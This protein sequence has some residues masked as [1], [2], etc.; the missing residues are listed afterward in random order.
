MTG[1]GPGFSSGAG[2]TWLENRLILSGYNYKQLTDLA[3]EIK[4][5]LEAYPRL[6]NVRTDLTRRYLPADVFETTLY[7]N[8]SALGNYRLSAQEV[9]QQLQPILSPFSY[10]RRLTISG[11][12]KP[13][14]VTSHQH[15]S[16][17]P[18]QLDV[19]PLSTSSGSDVRL[20]SLANLNQKPAPPLIERENRQYY[21]VIAFDYLA[22]YRFAEQFVDDFLEKTKVPVGFQ[23][24]KM[25]GFWLEVGDKLKIAPILILSFL[26][27]YMV[28]AGLYESFSYPLFIFLVIPFSLIGVFLIYYLTGA[29]F[30]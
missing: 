14:T 22:P 9:F 4:T 6:R 15:K 23:L 3:E 18:H 30:N 21:L 13:F 24:E 29:T 10:R 17:E 12:G 26:L 20:K 11:V 2:A 27:M 16:V 1:Y 7:F 19:L 28:L 5:N 8:R 25:L